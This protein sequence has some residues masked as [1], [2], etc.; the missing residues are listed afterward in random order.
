MFK[1]LM[2]YF[3]KGTTFIGLGINADPFKILV[4][5]AILRALLQDAK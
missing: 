5:K 3:G 1:F 2:R 4:W